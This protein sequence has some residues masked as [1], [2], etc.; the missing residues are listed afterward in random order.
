MKKLSSN[1]VNGLQIP[2]K[3]IELIESDKWKHPSNEILNKVIPFFKY[4][5]IFLDTVEKMERESYG[6]DLALEVLYEKNGAESLPWRDLDLSFF[7]AVCKSPGDDIGIALD[8]RTSMENPRVI[9]NNW[10]TDLEG[11]PWEEISFTFDEFVD[12]IGIK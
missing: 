4:D 1:T 11:S 5:V 10:H 2:S 9:G 8:F 6:Q 3:L 12:R 7:I